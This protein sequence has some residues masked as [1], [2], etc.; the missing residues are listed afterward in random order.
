MYD[1][2]LPIRNAMSTSC[3]IVAFTTASTATIACIFQL[4]LSL[5]SWMSL[6][7]IISPILLESPSQPEA[8]RHVSARQ[9]G[10]SQ[11][12]T[13][14]ILLGYKT[15][16]VDSSCQSCFIPHDTHDHVDVTVPFFYWASLHD[17]FL[18]SDPSPSV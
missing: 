10:A 12:E 14:E 13:S 9:R 11:Q 16:R 17:V 6:A 18:R 2:S 3:R 4:Q 1:H 5:E 15:C 8:F 7:C